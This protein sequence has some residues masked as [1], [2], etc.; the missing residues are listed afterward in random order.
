MHIA[1]IRDADYIPEAA[2]AGADADGWVDMNRIVPR[3]VVPYPMH[4]CP[5]TFKRL[6]ET[7]EAQVWLDSLRSRGGTTQASSLSIPKTNM[8]YMDCI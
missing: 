2:A 7:A 4:D 1:S 5:V 3:N 6:M 8:F